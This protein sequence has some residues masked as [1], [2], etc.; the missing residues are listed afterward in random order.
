[1]GVVVVFN[2]VKYTIG[3]YLYEIPAWLTSVLELR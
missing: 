3:F 2:E 1:M